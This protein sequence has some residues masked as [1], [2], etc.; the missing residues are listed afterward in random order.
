M[1]DAHP[2]IY[3]PVI[4]KPMSASFDELVPNSKKEIY[5]PRDLLMM[6]GLEI[7]RIKETI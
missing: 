4:L 2:L 5:Y 6:K 1:V 7:K 3:Y